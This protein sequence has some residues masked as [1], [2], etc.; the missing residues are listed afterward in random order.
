MALFLRAPEPGAGI[1]HGG[2]EDAEGEERSPCR[3]RGAG[4]IKPQGCP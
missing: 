4:E 2:F 3:S 1:T